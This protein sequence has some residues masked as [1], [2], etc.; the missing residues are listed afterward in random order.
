MFLGNPVRHP[1]ADLQMPWAAF[2]SQRSMTPEQW[3]QVREA[4]HAIVDLPADQRS[5]YLDRVCTEPLLRQEV[6][7]L[8]SNHEDAGDLLE[9]PSHFELHF[10]HD[11]PDPWV[12]KNIGPY[13]TISKIGEGGMGAVYRAVRVDDHYLKQVAIKL[14]R[15]GLGTGHYLR[16]FKNERQIM[17]SLDH[18]NIARL[19]DGGATQDGLPYL[20]MEYIE[21]E[22]IDR[23]CDSHRLDTHQRLKLFRQVCSALQYAHQNLVVHR[24]LKPGNILVMADG[25]PKLLDFGIAKLLDPELFFQTIDPGG[26]VFRAM[27]PEYAS[28]EQARGEPITT[29]S[30]IYSLGVILYRLLTGHAPYQL[31]SRDPLAMARGISQIEPEKPSTIID[32]VEEVRGS[33]GE[34][35]RVTPEQISA[36]RN[37]RHVLLR[38]RLAGDLDNIVLKAL[39]KEPSRRYVSAEQL[40]EDIQRYL[41]GLPVVARADTFTYRTSKFVTRHKAGV[42][43]AAM[44]FLTLVA[45]LFFTV[46]EARIAEAQRARAERRFNDVRK[47]ARDLMLDVHDSIQYLPGATPA[48]KLIIHDALEYLDSLAKESSGDISL[49]RELATAYE[50]VGDVQGWDVRSNLGDTAGALQSFR[51]S[52][53]IRQVLAHE[54]PGDPQARS[55][56]AEGYTKVGDVLL[57]TGDKIGALKNLDEALDIRKQLAASAPDDKEAKLNLAIAY[58]GLGNVLAD[59]NKLQLSLENTRQSLALFESLLA[60]DP[61]DRRY[62]RDIALEHKKVGGIY[63]AT[64]KLQAALEEYLK[65]LPV[66]Q[67]LS[68]ENPNDALAQRDL[69]IDYA[70]VGDILLKTGDTQGALLRYQQAVGIDEKLAKADPKDAWARRY[71][72]YNYSRVGDALLKMLDR[73]GALSFYNKALRLSEARANADPGNASAR[74]DMAQ[75]YS[76]LASAHFVFGSQAR[77]G[78]RQKKNSLLEARSW[79]QKSLEIWQSLQDQGRLS[80]IHGEEPEKMTREVSRCQS[81]LDQLTAQTAEAAATLAH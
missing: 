2:Y 78:M 10:D 9:N 73:S 57:Q 61:H 49:Q 37:E 11:A 28:P 42:G 51:K 26:T 66:D 60:L 45:G 70:N 13:Q 36:A 50:K 53:A 55:D 46:R 77:V 44:V 3:S 81:A 32:R 39:R 21:G 33:D 65:A 14:V 62:R 41:D 71:L 5:G 4:F 12:G 80:G 64:G 24:D 75:T 18:P 52:L 15:T 74:E 54:H 69:S 20:V 6:E 30:D 23:Y 16:R 25:T 47:L 22:E 58:D 7:S 59:D 34:S 31:D 72:I 27:T 35:R 76:K 43:A 63:E 79:Y 56:L 19:L 68:T 1:G 40:S 48:R 38:R 8:L 17:A 29:A 67:T